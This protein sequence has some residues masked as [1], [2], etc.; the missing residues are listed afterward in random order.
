MIYGAYMLSKGHIIEIKDKI[1]RMMMSR[2]DFRGIFIQWDK[3]TAIVVKVSM[4]S[5]IE[6]RR[7]L[8]DIIDGVMIIIKEVE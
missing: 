7:L 2:N 1:S 3:V 4:G 6:V 5:Y 8:G